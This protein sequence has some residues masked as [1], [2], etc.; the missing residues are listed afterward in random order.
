[1]TN[2]ELIAVAAEVQTLVR[3]RTNDPRTAMMIYATAMSF[4]A[5]EGKGPKT[6]WPSL[7]GWVLGMV[8][9]SLDFTQTLLEQH[10]PNG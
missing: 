10:Q 6:S 8:K 1:M 2:E 7:Q 9:T 3:Q 4:D 5:A